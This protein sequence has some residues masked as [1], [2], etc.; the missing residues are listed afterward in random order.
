MNYAEYVK[1]SA[2]YEKAQ[3]TRRSLQMTIRMNKIWLL[4][5]DSKRGKKRL[6]IIKSAQTQLNTLIIPPKPKQPIGYEIIVNNEF[7][8]FLPTDNIEIAKEQA[9]NFLGHNNFIL[10]A[11]PRYRD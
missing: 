8:G 11:K 4:N 7:I 3:T 1:A 10:N 9:K 6:A 2:I 5:K